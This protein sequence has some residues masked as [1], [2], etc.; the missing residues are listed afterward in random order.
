MSSWNVWQVFYFNKITTVNIGSFSKALTKSYRVYTIILSKF[1]S[2]HFHKHQED[3]KGRY[4]TTMGASFVSWC[5]SYGYKHHEF[6][7]RNK[8]KANTHTHP[9]VKI[10]NSG[11]LM[12]RCVQIYENY[13]APYEKKILKLHSS[14]VYLLKLYYEI[15]SVCKGRYNICSLTE[16]NCNNLNISWKTD[17]IF[18]YN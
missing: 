7:K 15:L 18:S 12:C 10:K 4:V 3:R 9:I 11:K 17:L 1:S 5:F 14:C 16:I 8:I 6:R 13:R 2:I